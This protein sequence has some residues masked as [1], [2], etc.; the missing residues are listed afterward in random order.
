MK[1]NQP[2]LTIRVP[3]LMSGNMS[4][5]RTADFHGRSLALC[6][7]PPLGLLECLMLERHSL[8]FHEQGSL[9]LG[10][11]SEAA[12]FSGPWHRR[13]WP[14]GLTLVS[15]PLGRLSRS[16]GVTSLN[17]PTRC[18]SFAIDPKGILRYHLVHDLNEPA[19]GALLEI[20]RASQVPELNRSETHSRHTEYKKLVARSEGG[21][22]NY[23]LQDSEM[24][25]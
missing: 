7:L 12:F 9:L 17:T 11:I 19:M 18:H 25:G 22:P 8:K 23:A 6:F 16:Y 21:S 20:V 2:A 10:V 15:D 3:A 24:K 5:L 4:Y 1:I 14:R 13:L